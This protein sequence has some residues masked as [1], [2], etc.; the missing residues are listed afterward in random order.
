MLPAR[1]LDPKL[2]ITNKYVTNAEIA[3]IFGNVHKFKITN[4]LLIEE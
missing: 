1:R 2:E 3:K 4:P